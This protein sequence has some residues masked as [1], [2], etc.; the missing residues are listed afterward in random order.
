M[1]VLEATVRLVHE[2]AVPRAARCSAFPTSATA[3]DHVPFCNEH[4]PIALEGMDESHV[5]YMQ[6][7]GHVDRRP[8]DVP[9]R[10]RVADRASSAA[11]PKRKP[12]RTARGLM[13]AFKAHAA[14]PS[15]EARRRRRSSKSSSGSFATT[16]LGVDFEDSEPAR[17]L[18]GLGRLG[19]RSEAAGRLPA[20]VSAEAVDEYG[21]DG[22]DLRPLRSRLRARAASTSICSRPKESPSTASS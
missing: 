15:D 11:T 17:L 12:T 13:D 19:G 10:R 20:R 4:K 18:S 3:G 6:L 22:V 5:H 14:P 7:K 9:R 8:R 21:Y 2:P 1:T 16:A